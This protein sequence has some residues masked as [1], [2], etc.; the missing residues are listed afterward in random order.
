VAETPPRETEEEMTRTPKAPASDTTPEPSA[1][2]RMRD[3]T[4]RVVRVPKSD[5]PAAKPPRVKPKKQG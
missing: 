5:L 1:F 2:E 3:L 4:R